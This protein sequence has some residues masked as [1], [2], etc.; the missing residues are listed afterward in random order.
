M[1]DWQLTTL[2]SLADWSGGMTPS[3]SNLAFWQDGTIPWLSSKEIVGGVV[4]STEHRVTQT[5]L[6]RTSLRMIGADSVAIVVRS[7]ILKRTLPVALVPFECTV[8]QDLKIGVP[9]PITSAYFLRCLIEVNEQEI[10]ARLCKTGTTV[11]S[12]NVPALMKYRVHLP[13]LHEQRQIV[14]LISSVDEQVAALVEEGHRLSVAYRSASSLLWTEPTGELAPARTL[15]E[16]MRLDIERV[17]LVDGGT[18]SGAGV[19]GSGGGLIDKGEFRGS[20]TEYAAMNVLRSN[21]VVMRKLTAWEG[22]ITV[23]PPKFDG[24]VASNEFPTFTLGIDVSP[25]WMRHVCRT[26]RLWDEMKNRVTGTVQRRKRLNPEQLLS[27]ALPVPTLHQQER[28]AAA[29]DALESA[30]LAVARELTM[31][32]AFRSSLLTGLLRQEIEIPESFDAL[33]EEAI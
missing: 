14:D 29:L 4:R 16:V 2:G 28:A 12:L 20:E 3:K 9:K 19:L 22:P 1:S 24:Y 30:Q 8:N 25:G 33:L 5:A 18:Y 17:V 26:A 31:L 10:L 13:P 23:V 11:Q 32:R 27:V 15:G 21:Q 7:G 6:D